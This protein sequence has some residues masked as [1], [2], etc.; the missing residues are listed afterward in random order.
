MSEIQPTARIDSEVGT[1]IGNIADGSGG[2]ERMVP[3]IRIILK[4]ECLTRAA[5]SSLRQP[6]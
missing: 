5:A 3:G 1:A 2:H 6:L 4:W